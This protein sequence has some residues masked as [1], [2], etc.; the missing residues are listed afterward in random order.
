MQDSEFKTL[1]ETG[2]LV[3][4]L[5]VA[6]GCGDAGARYK[7]GVSTEGHQF[8]TEFGCHEFSK[9]LQAELSPEDEQECCLEFLY[10]YDWI[11]DGIQTG[12]ERS[13]PGIISWIK[14]LTGH[15]LLL[16]VNPELV[17]FKGHFPGNPILPGIVQL[18]WAVGISMSLFGFDEVPCEVN[19]LKF[20]NIVQPPG[21]LE[22]QLEQKNKTGV[23]FRFTSFGRVHSM[24]S[25]L[26][27]DSSS[28]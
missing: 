17:F 9:R 23:Q 14:G 10:D 22:L 16:D 27:R 7:V 5:M 8:I 28:C 15:R 19:R 20:S 1:P 4:R 13:K 25:L 6:R 24:G 11:L 3:N 12:G 21:V 26:F 18:H 2:P